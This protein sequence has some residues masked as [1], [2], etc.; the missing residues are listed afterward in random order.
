MA[1]TASAVTQS[2]SVP[3]VLLGANFADLLSSQFEEIKVRKWNQPTQGL[4]LFRKESTSKA[5]IKESAVTG[6]GLMP[7]NDDEDNLPLDAPYQSF[8]VTMTPID[9]RKA[10]RVTQKLRETDQ[11]ST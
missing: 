10:V 9:Y 5:Y 6:L 11:H 3:G 1:V 4:A 8:D 7:Q 2:Y